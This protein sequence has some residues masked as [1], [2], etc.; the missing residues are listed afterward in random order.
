MLDLKEYDLGLDWKYLVGDSVRHLK[1]G[2]TYLICDH[3][4]IEENL[5]PAYIYVAWDGKLNAYGPAW[6]S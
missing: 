3:S 2:N 4:V 5:T 6:L 1:T